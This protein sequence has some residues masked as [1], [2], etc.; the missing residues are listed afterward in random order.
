MERTAAAAGLAPE[1]SCHRSAAVGVARGGNVFHELVM[2]IFW[3]GRYELFVSDI[4]EARA[5]RASSRIPV[6]GSLD[7]LKDRLAKVILMIPI[8]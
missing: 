2:L 1:G 5:T 6:I 3:L 4:D 7:D 8:R